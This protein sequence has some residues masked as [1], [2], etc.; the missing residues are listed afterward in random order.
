MARD[1]KKNR[2]KIKQEAMLD[3]KNR[4]NV[5]DPTPYEAVK[6][7]VEKEQQTTRNK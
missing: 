3:R 7:I 2:E 6:R 1:R 5:N 4:F